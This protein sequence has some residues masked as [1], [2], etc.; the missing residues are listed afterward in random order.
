MKRVKDVEQELAVAIAKDII[1]NAP[2]DEEGRMR[3]A[4]HLHR[5]DDSPN[6]L[7][8]LSS[9]STALVQGLAQTGHDS[10]TYLVILSS[11]PSAQTTSS[12][13]VVLVVGSDDN[14]VKAA[15]DGLKSKLNVKGGGKGTRWSGKFVGVWKDAREGASAA[16]V[17]NSCTSRSE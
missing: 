5:T 6:T 7:A 15:G 12:T 2:R 13:T 11:S 16:E 17:L 4:K 10:G 8:L 9:I 1:A 14:T 3:I